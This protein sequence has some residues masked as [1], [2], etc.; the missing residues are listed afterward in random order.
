MRPSPR[1]LL[2]L[3]I[4]TAAAALL[5]IARPYID[6][7]NA[8]SALVIPLSSTL[9]LSLL[10]W[11]AGVFLIAAAATDYVRSQS[12]KRLQVTREL[13]AGLSLGV[14]SRVQLHITHPL[15]T[16]VKLVV[17]DA[18]PDQLNTTGL[19]ARVSI[20]PGAT[21]VVTYIIRPLARGDCTFGVADLRATS[22]WQL[23]QLRLRLGSL[24]TV[25]VYPNFAAINHFKNL[26]HDQQVSQ[27]GIH[28]S[29]RRGQGMDFNQLREFREGDPL[30]QV[31]WKAS[32]RMRKLISRQYQDE[33]DQDIVFLLD[34]GRRLRTKDGLLSHFDHCLNALLLTT[35]VACNQGDAVGL[36]TFAGEQ[37]WYK[38]K[39][40]GDVVTTLL[41]QIY[42]LH[43]STETSDFIS[44]A[45]RLMDRH[46]KRSLII[47]MTNA[48]EEDADSLHTAIKL[49]T[50][51]HLVM[52]ASLRENF[53]D[54]SLQNPVSTFEDALAYCGSVD[55]FQRRRQ[56]LQQLRNTGVIISDCLPEQMYA[57]LVNQYFMLKRNGR[58]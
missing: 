10:W 54:Q 9:L 43:S 39:K 56:L 3:G 30:R 57:S 38:P 55:F 41:N 14:N 20:V 4:W 34:C 5:A 6:T 49:L 8:A 26:G 24:Q 40:G 32:A 23:W 33:R 15:A 42:D 7:D 11:L 18:Y 2:I 19:P 51:R 27:L 47:L 53:L 29:Q 35:Y 21:A 31:D 16:T 50:R 12:L 48:R 1:L 36:M 17:N 28:M 52:V 45:E 13:P 37:R 44:A 25:K 58:I 46:R 22:R